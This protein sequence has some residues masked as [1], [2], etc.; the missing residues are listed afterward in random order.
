MR[1]SPIFKNSAL[2]YGCLSLSLSFCSQS[3]SR[4]RAENSLVFASPHQESEDFAG[5]SGLESRQRVV[6]GKFLKPVPDKTT[7]EILNLPAVFELSFAEKNNQASWRSEL[8]RDSPLVVEYLSQG[9]QSLQEIRPLTVETGPFVESLT[10]SSVKETSTPI[11]LIIVLTSKTIVIQ[12]LVYG[13]KSVEVEANSGDEELSKNKRA[14]P[15]SKTF[16]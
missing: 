11:R 13:G 2:L 4:K 10:F 16:Q 1:L 7:G 14:I 9:G 6:R 15:L 5:Q 3:E 8:D 12:E